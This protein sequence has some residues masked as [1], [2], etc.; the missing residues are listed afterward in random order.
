MSWL[1][2][3][4]RWRPRPLMASGC[5]FL[6]KEP[7]PRAAGDPSRASPQHRPTPAWRQLPFKEIKSGPWA[8]PGGSRPWSLHPH[9]FLSHKAGLRSPGAGPGQV[10]TKKQTYFGNYYSM[11]SVSLSPAKEPHKVHVC[12]FFLHIDEETK[13]QRGEN[14]LAS[15]P[16]GSRV[17]GNGL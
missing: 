15:S 16:P 2:F 6:W 3:Q 4:S 12:L 17:G 5:L 11:P 14:K 1:C 8:P 7:D 13:A 9:C 10:L